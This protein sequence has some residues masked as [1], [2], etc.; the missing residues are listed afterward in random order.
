[1]QLGV[2]EELKWTETRIKV[3]EVLMGHG[4]DK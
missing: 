1:M 2:M 3:C 4:S